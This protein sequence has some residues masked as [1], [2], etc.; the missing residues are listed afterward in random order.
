LHHAWA[1][2][3]SLFA[4]AIAPIQFS[5]FVP[6]RASL[7]AKGV[8]L[9]VAMVSVQGL[10]RQACLDLHATKYDTSSHPEQRRRWI[11]IRRRAVE[12][13]E[14]AQDRHSVALHRQSRGHDDL[15]AA[16]HGF[17]FHLNYAVG[18]KRV[19]QIQLHAAKYR[20]DL[21]SARQGVRSR[22]LLASED[23][24]DSPMLGEIAAVGECLRAPIC[25]R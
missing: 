11:G 10:S 13:L 22:D 14:A 18:E 12:V 17:N 2:T 8:A 23:G 9:F 20:P 1:R 3:G 15:H 5:H 19:A 25:L 7:R 21:E 24:G 6:E 16:K 4:S